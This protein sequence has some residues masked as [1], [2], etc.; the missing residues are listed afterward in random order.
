MEPFPAGKIAVKH[1]FMISVYYLGRVNCETE[2]PSMPAW[3]EKEVARAS[4]PSWIPT[5]LDRATD[6]CKHMN[7]YEL[8]S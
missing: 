8:V 4:N 7:Y 1:M 2:K 3:F 5:P 6:G